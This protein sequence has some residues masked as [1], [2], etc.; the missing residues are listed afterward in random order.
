[1]IDL[2]TVTTDSFTCMKATLDDS[3]L[4]HKRFAHISPTILNE[5]NSWDLVEGLPS[6]KFEQEKM[7]DSCARCKQVRSSFKPKE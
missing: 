6:I 1:M 4:W 5:L 2:N 3:C 7:C